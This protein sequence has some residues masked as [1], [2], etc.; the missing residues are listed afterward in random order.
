MSA[1]NWKQTLVTGA[2]IGVIL[3]SLVALIMVVIGLEP[4]SLGSALAIFIG[5]ILFS[6]F[7]VKKI[8]QAI[9]YCNPSL[10]QLFPISFLTFLIPILSITFGAPNSNLDTI[11]TL[12]A[13]GTVGG[14]F[15]SSPFALWNYYKG[16]GNNSVTDGQ[17]NITRNITI[18]D[19]VVMG[20]VANI[21]AEE[22]S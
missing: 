2:G 14:L 3:A 17:H 6:A 13:I 1:I 20:N 8:S 7:T 19:S 10:K 4:P 9:G 15:W 12:I 16:R 11:L 5:M 22:E 18:Q 21:T